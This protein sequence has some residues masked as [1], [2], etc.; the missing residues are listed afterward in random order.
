MSYIANK[1]STLVIKIFIVVNKISYLDIIVLLFN[2][3]DI[4]FGTLGI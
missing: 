3:Y 2:I 1:I 4:L